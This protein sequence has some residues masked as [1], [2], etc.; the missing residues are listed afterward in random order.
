MLI[1]PSH[2][3]PMDAPH[4]LVRVPT[5]KLA[6]ASRTRMEL[7]FL[8]GFSFFLL[9][10]LHHVHLRVKLVSDNDFFSFSR[11]LDGDGRGLVVAEERGPLA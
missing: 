8:V 9:L 5:W 1:L 10:S 3:Q 11:L 4:Q 2:L 7:M 6:N